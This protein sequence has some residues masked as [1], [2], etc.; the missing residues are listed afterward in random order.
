MS[1]VFKKRS[2][3]RPVYLPSLL[4]EAALGALLPILPV[5]ATETGAG[6]AAA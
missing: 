5:S 4:F 6:L 2:L 3:A 1:E